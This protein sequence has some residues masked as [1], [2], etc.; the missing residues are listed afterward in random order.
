M[1]K[2]T[3]AIGGLAAS[4]VTW[5]TRSALLGVVVALAAALLI[6]A[7]AILFNTEEDGW[8]EVDRD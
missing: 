5:A 6:V 8:V 4:V 7:D 3:S 2:L 1:S